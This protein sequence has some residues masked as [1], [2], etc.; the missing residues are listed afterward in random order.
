MLFRSHPIRPLSCLQSA[1]FLINSRSHRFCAT[2][3][4]SAR[5]GLHAAGHA[6]SRSY[7]IILPSSFTRVLPS[8]LVS[9]TSPPVSVSGTASRNLRLRGFSWKHGVSRF[10]RKRARTRASGLDGRPDLPRRPPYTLRPALPTAG[11]PSLLRHPVAVAAGTGMLTRFPSTTPFGLA[12]G[13]D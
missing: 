10:A 11:R 9:S 6:F 1:V 8:A 3:P 13:A 2:P 4:R 12:L 7:G 5:K